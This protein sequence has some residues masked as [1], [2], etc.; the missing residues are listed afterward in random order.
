MSTVQRAPNGPAAPTADVVLA[1]KGRSFHWARHLLGPVHAA[2][3]TRLYAFCRW[4]DDLADEASSVDDARLALAR[5]ALAVRIG[6]SADPALRD[7]LALMR[8]CRIDP[9]FVLE[10]IKGVTSDLDPVAIDDVDCLLRYCYRVAGSVGLMMCRVLDVDDPA[11]LPHAVDLGIAMQLTNICRDVADDA[12]AGRRYIP[13]S[14]IGAVAPEHLVA[15]LDGLRSDAR[16]CVAALLDLADHYY[17]SGELGLPYLPVR[18]RAGILVAARLY[19]AIGDE[20]RRRECD[21]W[22]GRVVVRRRVKATLTAGA[23]LGRAVRPSF[24]LAPRWH[25]T[26]LHDAIMG[27]PCIAQVARGDHG[28]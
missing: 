2:R 6:V 20:L 25:D 24:W 5:A 22:S 23:L 28:H 4:I 9:A 17:R 27:L 12:A 21:C 11:A 3:A 1:T 14:M 26:H 19:Q 15:P 10:L 13:A 16:R 8:A 7:M 18:A